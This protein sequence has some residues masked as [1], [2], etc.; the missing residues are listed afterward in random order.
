[1]AFLLYTSRTS[2]SMEEKKKKRKKKGHAKKT[3]S[4]DYNFCRNNICKNQTREGALLMH[5]NL[6]LRNQFENKILCEFE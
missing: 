5:F 6:E 1:M 4:Q 2:N 3:L